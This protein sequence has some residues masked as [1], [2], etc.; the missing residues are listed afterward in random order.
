MLIERSPDGAYIF[1]GRWDHLKAE[2]D[3]ADDQHRVLLHDGRPAV[4]R[5]G[6]PASFVTVHAKVWEVIRRR[7]KAAMQVE[8]PRKRVRLCRGCRS[9]MEVVRE[10]TE[11]WSFRCPACQSVDVEGKDQI[12]GPIGQGEKEKT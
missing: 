9:E 3:A 2:W 1:A 8:P 7:Q 4:K 6:E 12:G 10:T 5:D 11:C